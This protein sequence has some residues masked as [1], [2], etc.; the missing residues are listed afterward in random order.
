M[1]KRRHCSICHLPGHD[2][3]AHHRRNPESEQLAD[4]YGRATGRIINAAGKGNAK[5]ERYWERSAQRVEKVIDDPR[6]P[7][8]QQFITVHNKFGVP[9]VIPR[10][11]GLESEDKYRHSEDTRN[12]AR[13][14]HRRE[15]DRLDR[16]TESDQEIAKHSAS[17]KRKLSYD[18]AQAKA[19]RERRKREVSVSPTATK[20]AYAAAQAKALR[21]GKTLVIRKASGGGSMAS[22]AAFERRT[23]GISR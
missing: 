2:R 21:E 19:A 11:Y 5:G 17:H 3:R 20:K 22:K 8:P 15:V 4:A 14:K 1:M 13:A 7:Y 10:R 23:Q 18:P 6:K 12:A 16:L 9:I